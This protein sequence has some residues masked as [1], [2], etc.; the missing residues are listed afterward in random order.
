VTY[1]VCTAV[2]PRS[3][4]DDFSNSGRRCGLPPRAVAQAHIEAAKV[5]VKFD[6][7]TRME[8]EMRRTGM[9]PRWMSR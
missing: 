8:F 4:S 2:R 6:A 3:G 7:D 5:D 9:T 1:A